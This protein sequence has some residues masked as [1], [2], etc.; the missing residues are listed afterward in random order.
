MYTV[1]KHFGDDSTSDDSSTPGEPV[2]VPNPY[3]GTPTWPTTVGKPLEPAQPLHACMGLNS[4]KGQDRFGAAGPTDGPRPGVPNDCAGQGYCATTKDHQCHVQN[5]CK[6]QGGC[7]LYGTAE[8]LN[9]PGNN[10]CKSLGSCATP[11]N[12]E[13]FSTNG[14]NRGKSVW[15]RAREVFHEKRWPALREKNPNLPEELPKVGGD[16]Y[17]TDVFKDGPAYLW[18]SNYNTA[19]GNMV[20]CG[21]SGMSGAGG[22][23]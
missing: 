19:R 15:L 23:G 2:P 7:G 18:V 8:E 17:V 1:K 4:C 22:C 11:I 16:A 9:H 20:S 3:K 6:D 13:R 14:P 10:D 12:A 21:S 5:Q